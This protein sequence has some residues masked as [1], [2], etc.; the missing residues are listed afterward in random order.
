MSKPSCTTFYAAVGDAGHSVSVLSALVFA[1]AVLRYA[2]DPESTVLFDP[3][4]KADGFCVAGKDS[5]FWTSHDVCLYLDVAMALLLGVFYMLLKSTEGLAAANKYIAANVVGVV[6]H[7]MG[8]GAIARAIRQQ[9]GDVGGSVTEGQRTLLVRL[10]EDALLDVV[11]FAF[12]FLIF[13][14]GLLWASMPQSKK[15]FIIVASILAQL[16]NTLVPVHLAFTYVQT[17][18]L[19]C[20]SVNQT[21][22]DSREKGFAYA[23]YPFL[24]AIPT[25]MVG[26]I[27]STQCSSF[28]RST[29]HG[30]V[31]YD[32]YIAVSL[33]IWYLVCYLQAKRKLGE[34]KKIV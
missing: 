16:G 31:I 18:L 21:N 6:A 15:G 10:Q 26:W 32:G 5:P 3:Q 14:V 29:F 8:H 4:W 9:V 22:L 20:F 23:L 27:E 7:G 34:D 2:G 24:V 17:V 11:V 1:G 12:P 33:I 30:H 25:I 19:L 28:V 13:W